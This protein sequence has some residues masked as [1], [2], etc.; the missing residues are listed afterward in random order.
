MKWVRHFGERELIPIAEATDWPGSR[1]QLA[2]EAAKRNGNRQ[3]TEEDRLAAREK[4]LL[5]I[6]NESFDRKVG[7]CRERIQCV[8]KETLQKLQG[9]TAESY[10]GLPFGQ[11]GTESS[12]R[13]YS[14][15]GQR[16]MCFC[17]RAYRLSRKE[18]FSKLGMCFTEEQWSLMS[19]VVL[20]AEDEILHG[21]D[22]ANVRPTDD[23][24]YYSEK[25]NTEGGM[26]SLDECSQGETARPATEGLDRAVFLFMIASI[27]VRV[28]GN[29]Y[30]NA[31]L[32]FCAA[33]GIHRNPAGYESATHYTGIMAGL[34]WL[35]QLFFLEHIF[36][37][38]PREL[39]ELGLEALDRFQEEFAKWIC[40][41]TYTAIS[42]II[43]W[44]AYG[45]GH[46]QKA[47]GQPSVRW[48]ES[49]EVL[50]HNGEGIQIGNFTK[51]ACS[52]IAEADDLLNELL[53]GQ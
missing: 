7:R 19:D 32:C 6:L 18:A 40:I 42:K 17:M 50:F 20:E 26:F 31:L 51:L 46:R 14:I 37:N 38:E 13:K 23:S 39:E 47:E 34:H 35:S 2:K 1:A 12:I 45:K 33:M 4:L 30:S 8:P 11:S 15:I 25:D 53:G 24:G 48:G 9:I 52:M 16:Y 28:G 5:M 27:K 44:M 49:K 22:A 3:Q 41:G 43:N 36:E 10:I 21:N 29:I